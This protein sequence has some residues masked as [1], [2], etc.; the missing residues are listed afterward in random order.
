MGDW[1]RDSVQP[2][3]LQNCR[4]QGTMCS[5]GGRPRCWPQAWIGGG[6]VGHRGGAGSGH[7]GGNGGEVGGDGGCTRRTAGSGNRVV[8]G[9]EV[10]LSTGRGCCHCEVVGR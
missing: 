6:E 7:G 8:V 4:E 10:E 1:E 5:S 2:G 3:L 9:N